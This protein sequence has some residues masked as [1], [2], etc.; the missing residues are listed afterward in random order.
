MTTAETTQSDTATREQD[1]LARAVQTVIG[2]SAALAP[3][4]FW[5]SISSLAAAVLVWGAWVAPFLSASI[6]SLFAGLAALILLAAP[7]LFLLK[8]HR[9][10]R[11]IPLLLDRAAAFR[12]VLPA[13]VLGRARA[14]ALETAG[15][16]F[17]AK[18][19][20][21]ARAY[22]Q[23][24]LELRASVLG[25]ED[26]LAKVAGAASLVRFIASPV[27]FLVAGFAVAASAL[28]SVFGAAA[29][30]RLIAGA[31]G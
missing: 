19:T 14:R 26:A 8:A 1:P 5:L 28:L 6:V 4:F 24:V 31:V 15:Q 10:V 30:L 9:V 21:D 20:A 25:A 2:A 16:G 27:M 3:P 23:T 7:G 18:V 22:A 12:N 13:D 11:E 17:A 29:L